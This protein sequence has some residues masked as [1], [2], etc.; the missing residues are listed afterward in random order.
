MLIFFLFN[1]HSHHPQWL[2]FS[3]IIFS[4]FRTC[5]ILLYLIDIPFS[6]QIFGKNYSGSSEHNYISVLLITPIIMAKPKLS[7]SVWK[8]ICGVFHLTEKINGI[9]GYPEMNGGIT[10][11][12]IPLLARLLL[13]KPI[14]KIH[15][16][17]FPTCQGPR[18]FRSLTKLLH[19]MQPFFFLSNKICSWLGI[20]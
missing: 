14:D 10:H 9:S 12:S 4:C 5:L 8:H 7:T 11:I 3:W 15:C 13:K 20:L 19:S 2:R 1:I 17:L 6:V 16:H 18:R